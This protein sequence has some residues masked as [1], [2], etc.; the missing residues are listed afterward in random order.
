MMHG[1]LRGLISFGLVTG[2]L[3]LA[4]RRDVVLP[5]DDVFYTQPAN[6]SDYQPGEI[7]AWRSIE[8]DLNGLL[9]D[10]VLPISL[11][12]SYQFLYRTVDS[13]QNPVATVTTILVPHN[14]NP[15]KLLSYQSAYDSANI[16]CAPS[17]A[18]QA[19][20]N[21]VAVVDIVMVC[22]CAMWP[23]LLFVEI[24]QGHLS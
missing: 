23:F 7:I 12:A 11:N 21:T 19:G 16:N 22:P 6:I 2:V 17:Y 10:S 3:G 4:V 1:N 18:F 13:F 5:K 24:Q 8:P 9:G 20:A 15:N 14:A